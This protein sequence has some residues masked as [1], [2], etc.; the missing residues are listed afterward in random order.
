MNIWLIWLLI[1]V[2]MFI[3]EIFTPGFFSACLGIAAAINAVLSL[4]LPNINIVWQIIIFSI[5]TILSFI[6]IRPFAIKYLYKNSN[7]ANSNADGLIGKRGKITKPI[8]T[9]NYGFMKI[10]GDEF[11]A[12]SEDGKPIEEGAEV[13]IVKIDGIKVIVRKVNQ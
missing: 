3:I 10:Y 5:L 9:V 6:L 12:I 2:I 11:M 4:I 13:E 8:D 7:K 1:S